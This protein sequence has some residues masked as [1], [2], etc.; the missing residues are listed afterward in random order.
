MTVS[1]LSSS[2]ISSLAMFGLNQATTQITESTARLSSGNRFYRAGDDIGALAQSNRIRS[3]IVSLT[4]AQTNNTT[5]NSMLQTAYSG[6]SEINDILDSMRSL[7]VQANS[8]SL[9]AAERETLNLQLQEYIEQIDQIAG[10]TNFNGINLLDGS[11]SGSNEIVG[12][13]SNS[14]Q[15]SAIINFTGAAGGSAVTINGVTLNEG[16][17]FTAGADGTATATS[18]MNALSNTSN[19]ALQA[20]SY[21]RSGSAITVTARAGGSQGNAIL[22]ND[23]GAADITTIGN[24]TAVANSFQLTGGADTGISRGAVVGRGTIGDSLITAQSQTVSQAVITIIDNN[25]ISN[26]NEG[27]FIIDDGNGGTITFDT[28]TTPTAGSGEFLRGAT[29]EETLKNL[30][31]AVQTA[32]T[33]DDYVLDQLTFEVS[34]NQL[35]VRGRLPGD[36]LDLN[37]AAAN[38]TET[39]G[40]SDGGIDVTTLDSGNDS[41]INTA[42][43]SSADFVGTISGFSA[44]YNSADD[45]TVNLTVGDDTF[46][47]EINDTDPT[48]NT[49]IGFT[50]ATGGSFTVQLA[51]NQGMSVSDQADADT[52]AARLDAAFSGVTF[53]QERVISSYNAAGQLAGGQAVLITDDYSG[54]ILIED[55]SVVDSTTTGNNAIVELTINGETYRSGSIGTTV[56][57]FETLYLRNTSDA[58]K[59]LKISNGGGGVVD[60]STAANASTFETTLRNNFG[61]NSTGSGTLDFLIGNSPDDRLGVSIGSATADSLFDGQTLDISTQAGAAA[62]E[63]AIDGAQEELST[64]IA[65]IGSAQSRLDFAYNATASTLTELETVRSLLADTDIAAESTDYASAVVQQQAAISVLAQTAVLSE[66]LL[67]LLDKN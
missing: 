65:N 19:A 60:L 62:A 2:A 32:T 66:N 24:A 56:G 61:L 47:A 67:G 48:T 3:D 21:S 57:S 36:V 52:F 34:G 46:T 23:G 10:N 15:A 17:D 38:I 45:I 55:V 43:V 51:A 63:T 59:M 53:S 8:G 5:A 11:I 64:I 28:D 41:G 20:L 35:I 27:I 49:T 44:T 31:D 9:T 1:T 42:N 30:V 6:A 37:G 25:N 39:M 7:S 33:T 22:I 12:S 50:S 29:A 26:N 40:G 16:A 58:N 14:Q 13:E 18:L 54:N 4:Q